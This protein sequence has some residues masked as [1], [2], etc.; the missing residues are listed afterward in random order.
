M[1]SPYPLFSSFLLFVLL[2]GCSRHVR[3]Q[4]FIEGS[5][6]D[7]LDTMGFH[8]ESPLDLPVIE[9]MLSRLGKSAF[10]A[11]V[12]QP[13][14]LYL[15]VFADP[16][17]PCGVALAAMASSLEG[18]APLGVLQMVD[19]WGKLPD[20]FFYGV[21]SVVGVGVYSECIHAQAPD[22]GIKG[23]FCTVF[24]NDNDTSAQ[25]QREGAGPRLIQGFANVNINLS[26]QYSTCI[27]DACSDLE[28]MTSVNKAL[29]GLKEATVKCQTLD[30]KPQ[31]TGADIAFITFLSIMLAL[32]VSGTAVDVF[33]RVAKSSPTATGKLGLIRDTF[34]I[35]II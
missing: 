31:F 12:G 11:P 27:P 25:S 30:E 21:P 14:S 3:G 32:L 8:Q 13:W 19:S 15:P 16:E 7:G 2:L 33:L 1:K 6:L 23:K 22:L 10:R 34:V 28:L 20:G 4:D 18:N 17:S 35:I 29:D 9:K 26:V 5:V 24:L